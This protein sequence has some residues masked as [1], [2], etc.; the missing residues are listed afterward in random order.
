MEWVIN[1]INTSYD[2]CP[3]LEERE[4]ESLWVNC[5]LQGGTHKWKQIPR[6][7]Y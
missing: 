1:G 2:D 6:R 5:N 7:Y 3:S 4:R